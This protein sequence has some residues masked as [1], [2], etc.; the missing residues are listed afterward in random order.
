M[1]SAGQYIMSINHKIFVFAVGMR[2]IVS[3]VVVDKS[4]KG[5]FVHIPALCRYGNFLH[6][7]LQ[8]WHI[9]N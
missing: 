1:D 4:A 5:L 6:F 2:N 9:Y 8:L 7:K 3:V